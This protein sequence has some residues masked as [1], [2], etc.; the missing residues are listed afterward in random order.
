MTLYTA[1][2]MKTQLRLDLLAAMKE[3]RTNE[4]KLLRT[5]VAAID[6]AEAPPIDT[7]HQTTEQ[8]QFHDRSAE[9]ER[10]AL[11]TAQVR[12]VLV[13]ELEERESAAAE[14]SQVNRP[15]LANTLRSEAL[16]IKGYIQQIPI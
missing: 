2:G 1:E 4:V 6:N 15:E 7:N 12:E 11:T 16:I 14:L 5:L 8:L 10:L 13:A 9:I 3:G